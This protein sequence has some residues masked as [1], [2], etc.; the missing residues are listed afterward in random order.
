VFVGRLSSEKGLDVLLAAL[1][2]VGDPRFLIVGD[3][4]QRQRLEE[5]ARMLGL[6]NTRFLGFQ[7]SDQ[8]RELVANARYVAVPSLGEETA[9]LGA[10]EALSAGRPLLVSDRGALPELVAGGAG[11]AC[12][13]G[14]ERDISDKMS[15]LIQDDELCRHASSEA[16]RFA[17]EWLDPDLH[18]ASLE[19]VYRAV[20]A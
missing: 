4:I 18:L 11:L 9:N 2:R 14:D 5:L 19:S 8:V 6:A 17:R 16:S 1:R 3:G 10:L 20:C 15:R 12:R 7:S 13:P